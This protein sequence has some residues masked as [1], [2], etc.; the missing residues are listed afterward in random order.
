[1]DWRRECKTD[2]RSEK[3]KCKKGDRPIGLKGGRRWQTRGTAS[4]QAS[5]HKV[6]RWGQ[7]VKRKDVWGETDGGMM[8]RVEGHR[9]CGWEDWW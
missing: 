3:L 6:N 4:K 9:A 1:M 5:N 2:K 8:T 7:L